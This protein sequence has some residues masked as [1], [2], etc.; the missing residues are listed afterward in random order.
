M[1]VS[2]FDRHYTLDGYKVIYAI[3]RVD[4]Y[5]K[6]LCEVEETELS[7]II[8]RDKQHYTIKKIIEAQLEETE[9]R[10]EN[11]YYVDIR[12]G[13]CHKAA[14][15]NSKILKDITE[16]EALEIFHKES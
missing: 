3:I 1:S 6:L 14:S 11:S 4:N 16:E 10:V 9:Y 12:H 5:N 2:V 8:F 13:T 7:K 15:E